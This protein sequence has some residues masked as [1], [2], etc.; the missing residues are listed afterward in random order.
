MPDTWFGSQPRCIPLVA[1]CAALMLQVCVAQTSKD[2][3]TIKSILQ[4]SDAD[5]VAFAKSV[6]EQHFPENEGDRF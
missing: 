1:I 5:Q 6:L 4:V 3:E 2:A